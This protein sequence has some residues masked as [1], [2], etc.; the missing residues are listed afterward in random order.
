MN[1]HARR[2]TLAR[3]ADIGYQAQMC[4]RLPKNV[5]PHPAPVTFFGPRVEGGWKSARESARGEVAREVPPATAVRLSK[6]RGSRA[7]ARQLRRGFTLVELLITVAMIGVMSTLA[8]VGYRKY[9][10]SAQSSEAKN[11]I[12][13]IR[14]AQEAYK[15]EMLQYLS[16]STN[17]STF[18][19]NTT[20]NDVRYAWVFPSHADAP[21]WKQLNVNPDAPVRFG[22]ACIAGIAPTNSMQPLSAFLAPP[23]MPTLNSGTAWYEIQAKNDHNANGVFAVFGSTSLSGEILSENETE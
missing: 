12:Q 5:T 2:S 20:P 22:Y 3:H 9:L 11:V 23:T 16:P 19:P 21:N 4:A 8:M 14:G 7:R 13:M 10:Y 18:Y 6:P 17:I 1:E 15:A